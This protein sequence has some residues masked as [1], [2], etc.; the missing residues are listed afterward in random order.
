LDKNANL[1][2]N[3]NFINCPFGDSLYTFYGGSGRSTQTSIILPKK[4]NQYY[5]FSTGMSD[6]V[7]HILI[8]SIVYLG[9]DVLNY[10]VVDMD[11]NGGNG[12]VIEKNKVVLDNQRY[13]NCA[14]T[15]VKHGNG[16]DWWLVKADCWKHQYQ[17]FLVKEDT[18]EGPFYYSFTDTTNYW[19]YYSEIYFSDDGTKMAS[20][21]QRQQV[22]PIQVSY[23]E[24]NRVDIF[25]FDRCTGQLTYKN[26]YRV[27]SDSVNFPYEDG[28]AGICFSPNGKLL[29]M[30]NLYSI[31]QIDLED[32][33]RYNGIFIHGPDDSLNVFPSYHLGKCAPNGKLY[34][35]NF[36]GT[37]NAMSYI[38]SPN[39]RGLGCNF[40]AKGLTQSFNNNLLNPPNMPNYGLGANGLCAPASTGI[41]NPDNG[42]LEVYPNPC[43]AKLHIRCKH[44]ESKK[45]L[46][47]TVGQLLITTTKNEIDVSRF[48]KGVYYLKCETQT[49][50]LLIE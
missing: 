46:Y 11:S 38:D 2:Q 25:E 47:N 15:A 10:S 17:T 34:I 28:N 5:V 29:Y 12:K 19:N 4:G 22:T 49:R 3:G 32:T 45:E 43:S 31:Y 42:F 23:A 9:Y 40:V 8:D 27:P 44:T 1:I 50:R 36:D 35:G 30:M 39:V 16:R 26:Q 7:A 37:R 41:R 18:I 24:Y 13:A 20:N 14:M 21:I 6:S 48:I 33:N